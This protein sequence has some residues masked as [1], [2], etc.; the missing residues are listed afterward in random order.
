ML[1]SRT[2]AVRVAVAF[3][4]LLL[5]NAC[6]G[7]GGTTLSE[8]QRIVAANAQF[9]TQTA[10]L[11]T[12]AASEFGV[13]IEPEN[14]ASIIQ[15]D[16]EGF[17]VLVNTNIA[18]V[19]NLTLEDLQRGADVMF[20][21]VHYS[22][23]RKGFFVTRVRDENG[24]WIAEMRTLGGVVTATDVS[25]TTDDSI[26]Q[27]PIAT[28]NWEWG[29]IP[30]IDLRR[31]M[32]AIIACAHP[33]IKDIFPL[34]TTQGNLETQL[35]DNIANTTL[36]T[37]EQMLSSRS[38]SSSREVVFLSRDDTLVA[39]QMQSGVYSW[40]L[41]QLTQQSPM[42]CYYHTGESSRIV[43]VQI[44]NNN[45]VWSAPNLPGTRLVI[46]TP[47]SPRPVRPEPAQNARNAVIAF[48]IADNIVEIEF[49]VQ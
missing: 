19:E 6:G 48:P 9:R 30:C 4:A 42:T 17:R 40:T 20:S 34:R 2:K 22:D 28:A 37:M 15:R 14:F 12:R 13:T 16:S 43:P 23:G 31:R 44:T 7:G 11:L 32:F 24:T 39:V 47:S 27:R 1:I 8:E 49:P 18:G 21:F 46:K 26:A 45:G 38:R 29:D 41:E 35:S 10:S 33:V 25:V 5:L 36:N 3:S